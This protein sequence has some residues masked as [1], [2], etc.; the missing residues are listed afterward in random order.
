MGWSTK[1][2]DG[3]YTSKSGRKVVVRG[4]VA[5]W[6]D[7]PAPA[8]Q[9]QM[10]PTPNQDSS[11]G[12]VKG[13]NSFGNAMFA[14][15]PVWGAAGLNTLYDKLKE[16]FGGAPGPGWDE[17]LRREQEHAGASAGAHPALALA[18]GIASPLNELGPV[19][20]G[21][22]MAS[23]TKALGGSNLESTL[24]GLGGAGFAGAI[25]AA[26]GVAKS[27]SEYGPAIVKGIKEGEGHYLKDALNAIDEVKARNAQ[28]KSLPQMP[29]RP[30]SMRGPQEPVPEAPK[31]T[32]DPVM[33]EPGT[34]PSLRAQGKL[35]PELDNTVITPL[36]EK[37]PPPVP[38]DGLEE[39]L[40]KSVEQAKQPP[41]A[42]PAEPG[43]Q[44]GIVPKNLEP[45][46]TGVADAA[47]MSK[48]E[49]SALPFDEQ[50][51]KDQAM[52]DFVLKERWKE[53]MKQQSMPPQEP[54]TLGEP[55]ASLP[56]ERMAVARKA[57]TMKANY[58]KAHPE[59]EGATPEQDEVIRAYDRM[60][61]ANP[62][63]DPWSPIPENAEPLRP[64]LPEAKKSWLEETYARLKGLFGPGDNAAKV[65][66][67]PEARIRARG[68]KP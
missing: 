13:I 4:G 30:P 68:E 29:R 1:L 31:T 28:P 47:K 14:G 57:D 20:T 61:K 59:L 32:V 56:P 53:Q 33:P 65:M 44:A 25:R 36:P 66:E 27:V 19:G 6:A 38:D 39:L 3:S 34:S 64:Q 17:N 7:E 58:Q 10:E 35:P 45:P 41:A 21:L 22:G 11:P 43:T 5:E 42:L 67:S 37:P 23:Y 26:P 49:A 62:V 54:I 51:A 46:R 18:G 12:W 55:P 8:A 52:K 15:A 40:R 16:K 50:A 60:R 9:A 2:A 48:N 63:E 24:S